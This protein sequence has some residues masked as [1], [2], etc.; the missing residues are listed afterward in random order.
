[1]L[2]FDATPFYYLKHFYHLI[3]FYNKYNQKNFSQIR[4]LQNQSCLTSAM[5]RQTLYLWKQAPFLRL[6]IPL[7][8]G[9]VL[10]WYCF[11][12]TNFAW[13]LFLTGVAGI[14]FFNLRISFLQYKFGWI[15]GLCI[16][17]LFLALGMFITFH[18][19][20]SH[21]QQWINNYYS[22]K[23]FITATLEEPLSE[24]QIPIKQM[25]PYSN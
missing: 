16:N 21:Q 7:I 5:P 1:V 20:I 12:K 4:L 18:K 24:K 10:Q 6:I 3:Y 14:I 11:N 2:I 17:C 8:A 19:D 23:D 15:N 22:G 25:H 13:I 9:I